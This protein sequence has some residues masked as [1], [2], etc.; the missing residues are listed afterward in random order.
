[1]IEVNAYRIWICECP[2]PE[3]EYKQYVADDDDPDFKS[4]VKV[5]CSNCELEYVAICNEEED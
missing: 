5:K 3:C 2:D 1:M 4:R